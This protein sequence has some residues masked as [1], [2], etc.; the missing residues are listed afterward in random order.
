MNGPHSCLALVSRRDQGTGRG[1]MRRGQPLTKLKSAGSGQL[2]GWMRRHQTSQR[3]ALRMWIVL[4]YAGDSTN[5]DVAWRLGATAQM[6]SKRRLCFIARRPY[7]SLN[8]RCPRILVSC[9]GVIV[10][11]NSSNFCPTLTSVRPNAEKFMWS[12]TTTGSA[13]PQGS[14]ARTPSIGAPTL[15]FRRALFGSAFLSHCLGNTW[16]GLS[17]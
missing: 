13:R 4:T 15:D 8:E 6:V 1:A 14:N 17:G 12:W 2:L 5:E 3:P 9:F 10:Q 11:P 16:M 7:G